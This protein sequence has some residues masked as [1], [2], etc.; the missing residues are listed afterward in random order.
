VSTISSSSFPS[1][2]P[3]VAVPEAVAGVGEGAVAVIEGTPQELYGDQKG[4]DE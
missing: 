2:A 4:V 3:T 1:S